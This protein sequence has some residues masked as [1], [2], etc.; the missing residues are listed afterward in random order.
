MIQDRKDNH[1][2]MWVMEQKAAEAG[3]VTDAG[4]SRWVGKWLSKKMGHSG[5]RQLWNVVSGGQLHQKRLF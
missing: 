5:R 1:R 2:G 4:F 3:A